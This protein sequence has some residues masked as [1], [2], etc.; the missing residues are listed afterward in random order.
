MKTRWTKESAIT[1]L[2]QLAGETGRLAGERRL[3]TGHMRWAVR[4]LAF[5]EEVFGQESRYYLTFANLSWREEGSFIVG[6][7]GDPGGSWDPS[8]S[9]ERR[10]QKAYVRQLDS[11]RGLLLAAADHLERTDL[12]DVYQGKNT[13]PESSEIVQVINLGEQKLRKVMRNKPD[14]E[15][16]VQDSFES[17]LIGA[18]ITYSRETDSIEYSSKTYTPD[19]TMSKIGLAV[20]IKLCNRDGREKEIIAEMNDD[21]LAYRTKYG[22]LLFVVYDNGFIRD[23]DRFAGSFE[24]HQNVLVRVIKH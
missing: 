8:A 17:L 5:L 6:G 11:A 16:E 15:K 14:P 4:T 1:E 24:G 23:T 21:I 18:G 9:I 19:F 3:S 13:P 20:D 12:E 10:D 2:Q 22:N 7:P